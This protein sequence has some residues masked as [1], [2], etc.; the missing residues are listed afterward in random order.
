MKLLSLNCRGLNVQLKRNLYF[1][2]FE[3]Y[4][5][6]CLQETYVTAKNVD[7]WKSQWGGDFFQIFGTT[8]SKGQIILMNKRFSHDETSEFQLDERCL[9]ISFTA[10]EKHFSIFN[11]YAPSVKGE[12]I[13]YLYSLSEK[14]RNLKLPDT[15]HLIL[16][17]D[18][19]MLLDNHLDVISGDPHPIREIKAFKKFINNFD[20][21]DC[22]RYK[23]PEIIDFSWS[24]YNPFIARRLDYCFCSKNLKQS[25]IDASMNHFSSTDHKAV[26]TIFNIEDFPRG[27]GKWYFNDLL[28]EENEY[29]VFMKKHIQDHYVTLKMQ[30]FSNNEVYD[31]LKISIRDESKA[32]S[33]NKRA[34]LSEKVMWE[35]NIRELNDKL[36]LNPNDVD[37]LASLR[38]VINKKE[39]YEMAQSKGALKRSRAKYI[40]S[41]EKNTKFFLN[42][43]KSRQSKKII[44][45]IKGKNGNIITSPNEILSELRKFSK[46]LMTATD[47]NNF[48]EVYNKLN[49]FIG[50][51][52][53]PILSEADKQFLEATITVEE[54]ESALKELNFDSSP[55]EDGLTPAFYVHFWEYLSK[56][57]YE[58]LIE[59][60]QN[61]KLTVT[62]RR[63]LISLLYKGKDYDIQEIPSWR[64]I[65]LTNTDYKIYSKVLATRVQT[66]IKSIISGNQVAYVKGRSISEH[67]RLVDDIINIANKHN[68]PGILVSLD[69]QKAFDTIS[70]ASILAAL[71]KFNFGPIFISYVET[72][73]NDTEAAIKNG[74][75]ISEFFPTTRGVRQG[76]CL[77]PLLF[78]IVVEFLAIKIRH[79]PQISGI[80]ETHSNFS[81]KDS[82]LLQYADD[83]NLLLKTTQCIA[84]ALEITEEFE[85][86]TGLKLNRKKSI[87]MGLGQN[88]GLSDDEIGISWKNRG[89]SMRVLGIYFNASVEASLLEDNWKPKLEEIKNTIKTWSRR[90][91][92]LL[93]KCMISKTFLLSKIAYVIQS[94]C[95]P[96]EVLN[97]FDTLLFRFLWKN[98]ELNTRAY[99]KIKRSVLCLNDSEG[100]INMISVRDQQR[101]ML[102]RWLQKG[103]C[104][105]NLT[106]QKVIQNIFRN[107]GGIEYILNSFTSAEDFK[108]LDQ[109][110]SVFW[111]KTIITW[112]DL[113]SRNEKVENNVPI[114]NNKDILYKGK[115]LFIGRWI[116]MNCKYVHDIVNNG[117]IKTLN[118]IKL[119]VGN[120]GGLIP[121]YLAVYN[122]LNRSRINLNPPLNCAN[123]PLEFKLDNKR[124]RDIFVKQKNVE[125]P[126]VDFW[127]RKYNIDIKDNFLIANIS[128]K[129]TKLRYLHFRLIHNVYPT[130][131][132]LKKMYLKD[133]N[134]CD[135]CNNIDF[136]D[137]AFYYC[138]PV[139]EFWDNLSIIISTNLNMNIII[140]APHALL[141]IPRGFLQ[142]CPKKIKEI[143]HIILIAKLSI[144][145]A[146]L[147]RYRNIQIIFEQEIEIRKSNFQFIK[148]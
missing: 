134:L 119:V 63:A 7:I 95:L 109:I 144:T 64:P 133:S 52:S 88:K 74:G 143:N 25:I 75:W 30:N 94:L 23:H 108:G 43:E 47:N 129:E 101:V 53:H 37:L 16:C 131:I 121:D 136:I 71:K 141:G 62:Q 68:L 33:R 148:C 6:I 125:M 82:K 120:Y 111:K 142:I 123:L 145:K 29:D 54:C 11:L 41:G 110:T 102:I 86:F 13:A 84:R 83:M 22:W 76:C 93:G 58:S 92:T 112:L 50:N 38:K 20:L 2:L 26:V 99:E 73:L 114:F 19:N 137:H 116:K 135:A 24:R 98:K 115:P 1:K 122:A 87:G 126:S 10:S 107:V 9:G 100:G 55:G 90:N 78:I 4:D 42:L 28:L 80:L 113:N 31:L 61:R 34:H 138:R 46:D 44:R 67:I 85:T 35:H 70:K 8:N 130:N 106:Q 127:K 65:S 97:Q 57:F 96:D 81:D 72:I 103:Y 45:S 15:T 36:I 117:N 140:T 60:I 49:S 3:Q 56:P 32:F 139:K 21:I 146:R 59:S 27:P 77:S 104:N 128:T 14:L 89:E 5:I 48:D 17:G 105:S 147:T 39:V 124:L 91:L 18:M 118:E 12:R 40:E 51:I 132:L 66:I 79:D 69:F